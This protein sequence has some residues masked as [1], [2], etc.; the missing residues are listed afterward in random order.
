MQKSLE[1]AA[2]FGWRSTVKFYMGLQMGLFFKANDNLN[3]RTSSNLD[4]KIFDYI[5]RDKLIP[6]AYPEGEI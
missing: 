5:N 4:I 2:G 3:T 6:W 1:Q